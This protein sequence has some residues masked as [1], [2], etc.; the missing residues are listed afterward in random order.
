MY[1]RGSLSSCDPSAAVS[2][3]K[4]STA[5]L[6]LLMD[7]NKAEDMLHLFFSSVLSEKQQQFLYIQNTWQWNRLDLPND[8]Y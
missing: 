7:A 6:N 1:K 4:F 3:K 5:L 8:N 2:A